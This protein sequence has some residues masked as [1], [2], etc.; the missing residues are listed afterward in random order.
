MDLICGATTVKK[1]RRT[2]DS[3]PL[4]YAEAYQNTLDRL[5]KQD[6][7]RQ[8]LSKHALLWVCNSSRPM[9]MTEFQHAIASLEED[10]VYGK[11]DLETERSIISSCLGLLVHHKTNQA[12][13]LVH[14][15][16][17]EVILRHLGLEGRESQ[18]VISKACLRYMSSADMSKGPCRSVEDLKTRITTWPFL[19]YT[20]R[21]YGYHIKQVEDE[22]L[23]DLFEFLH[24]NRFRQS[25]WQLLHFVFKV[26]SHSASTLHVA[27]YW[28]FSSLLRKIVD[29]RPGR[30]FLDQTDSH[31]WT[32]L[33][34]A[35]SNGR[36][37]AVASLLEAGASIDALDRG[38]WTPLFWGAVKGHAA[39]VKLLLERG[40]NPFH[41]DSG[42]FTCLHWS[43]LSGS[44][45]V[46][47]LLLEQERQR[48]PSEAK[49]QTISAKTLSVEEAK[50]LQT[51]KKA[52]NLLQLVAQT[53]NMD[54][55]EQLAASVDNYMYGING[56][57]DVGLNLREF[58]KVWDRTKILMSKSANGWWYQVQD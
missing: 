47:A 23:P 15:S 2:L 12:V 58:A 19:E 17:K 45:E 50:A 39:V 22:L 24:D 8:R 35:A 44:E 42:G 9:D 55:F 57:H 36:A 34:W 54:A 43:I 40:G 21:H 3:L 53:S 26:D 7:E 20:S 52:V 56:Y 4:D 29:G 51:P 46:A 30:D 32:G 14:A 1:L 33:H 16:A 49:E 27:C 38:E 13:E 11:Q 6:Q 41:V 10:A 25:A 18:I 48:E 5:S 31:G 37:D 28:G